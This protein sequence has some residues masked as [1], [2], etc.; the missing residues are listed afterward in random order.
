MK[1]HP[2]KIHLHQE[3]NE[4]DFNRRLELSELMME[5]INQNPS[6]LS[7]LL[8]F[9]DEATLELS[10]KVNP[11]NLRYRSDKNPHWMLEAC[12]Q[13]PQKLNVWGGAFEWPARS[14]DLAPLDYFVWGYVKGKGY[15]TK[16]YDLE[17]L[18]QPIII[19]LQKYHRI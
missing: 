5:E 6:F 16:L 3:L 8:V 15:F 19:F 11:H 12:T 14:P 9:S 18:M 1:F 7:Y 4:D 13:Y 17:E 2:Y 10:G